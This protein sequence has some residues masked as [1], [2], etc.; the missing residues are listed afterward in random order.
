MNVIIAEA[1]QGLNIMFKPLHHLGSLAEPHI[2]FNT[3]LKTQYLGDPR[4]LNSMLMPLYTMNGRCKIMFLEALGNHQCLD[5]G[6][7]HTN[8]VPL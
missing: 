3:T 6:E 5:L 1:M 2:L 4:K 7:L 8:L